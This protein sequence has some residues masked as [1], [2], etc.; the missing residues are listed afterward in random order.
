MTISTEAV[1]AAA[2]ALPGIPTDSEDL[3]LRRNTAHAMLAAALPHL[4][5]EIAAALKIGNQA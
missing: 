2:K 5:E 1:E 4:R 3:R